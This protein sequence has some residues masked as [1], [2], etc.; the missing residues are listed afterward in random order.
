M[1]DEPQRDNPERIE[2][3]AQKD[4]GRIDKRASSRGI[5]VQWRKA[6]VD[7]PRA[8]AKGDGEALLNVLK[9]NSAPLTASPEDPEHTGGVAES[10]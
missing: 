5:P 10:L 1:A 9:G 2:M 4:S 7:F 6:R 8:K 3:T